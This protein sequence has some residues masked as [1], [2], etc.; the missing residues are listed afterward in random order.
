MIIL[1]T[2]RYLCRRVFALLLSLLSLLMPPLATGALAYAAEPQLQPS[3]E[4]A[5]RQEGLAGAVWSTAGAG[6]VASTGA[7]GL[8]NA[9]T[10]ER[11]A[12]DSKVHVGSVAKT[13]LAMGVLRL[14]TEGKLSLDAPVAP[15]LPALAIDNPWNASDPVRVRHLLAHTSGL[16][17]IRFWQLFSM[18]PRADTPL[19][20]A[21]AG[22][23]SLLRV[24][25][26]PGGRY[27]YS[28]MGYALLGMLIEAASGERYEHYLD[29]K[30]LAP[31]GM[32]DSTFEFVGQD[33]AAADKRLAMGHFERGVAQPALAMYLR[34]ASQFTTTAADM[35]R[36]AVFLLGDGTVPGASA[37]RLV[38]A[39]FMEQLD[40]PAGTDAAQAGLRVGHGLA[41][42]ARDR[43]G[44]VGQCHPGVT[45][46][47][48]AMLCV[49]RQQ[50]RAFFI[51]FNADAET[52]DYEQ[53]YQRL[54]AGLA[55]TRAGAASAGTGMRSGGGAGLVARVAEEPKEQQEPRE[56]KSPK[57][58]KEAWRGVYVPVSFAVSSLAWVDIVFNF[59]R[60]DWQGAD[61]HFMPFQ[62]EA[63]VLK[64]AGEKLF[65]ASG[66]IEPTHVLL[67]SAD[68]RRMVSDGLH[69][70]EQ[71]APA[72]MLLLWLSLAAGLAGLAYVLL[73]GIWRLL[74]RRR[75]SGEHT[76]LGGDGAAAPSAAPS[77]GPLA[78][79]LAAPLAGTLALLLPVPLF[80]SQ[81]YLQL[82]DRTAASLLLVAVTGALPLAMA[83]GLWRAWRGRNWR[84]GLALAAVLQL[85]A[86]LAA[87]GLIP[88]RLWV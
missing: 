46:G 4:S 35:G 62:G 17:N 87:W 56:P 83:W 32:A 82:G 61:L 31:L 15:L 81:S 72:R 45:I 59:V 40:R 47:F 18:E 79:P 55:L 60:L 29:T 48:R 12:P 88:F 2:P 42:A 33:G 36:F 21:F 63:K 70:Y 57:E 50:G 8:K 16:D 10:G 7:A 64:P 76:R 30:I 78:A 74:P 1:T 25:A 75:R 53:F 37:A 68:G 44:V 69:T 27:A 14:V 71:V 24:N 20:A 6:G 38:R 19:A 13:V 86:V 34:P 26:R 51:A 52:A 22:D 43:H 80:L 65:Q 49:Y 77:A 67:R 58:P 41:L 84:D 9:A 39:D 5:L 85:L 11:M 54:L 28:S 73:C 23:P 3:I 66:R